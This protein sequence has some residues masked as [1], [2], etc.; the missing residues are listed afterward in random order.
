ML[1]T[2]SSRQYGLNL[3]KM[4]YTVAPLSLGAILLTAGG[5]PVKAQP[6]IVQ[7]Q[8][9]G[10]VI[11]GS[12]IP[13]H[14]PVN[15]YTGRPCSVSSPTIVVTPGRGTLRNSTLI[16]PTVI[17]STISNSVLV[18]PVIIN[19]PRFPQRTL[20]RSTIIYNPAVRGIGSQQ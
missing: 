11:Y 5:M 20:R 3:L 16:N 13:T 8:P 4:A 2:L 17:N 1:K 12:P 14:V 18:N 15:P 7:S 6:V 19:S 10:N 9:C